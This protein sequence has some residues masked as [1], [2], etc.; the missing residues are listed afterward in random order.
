MKGFCK[1]DLEIIDRTKE[2]VDKAYCECQDIKE[3]NNLCFM[4]GYLEGLKSR[5]KGD[6]EAGQNNVLS[7]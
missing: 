5:I 1:M 3:K 4:A 2:L 7:S 6:L